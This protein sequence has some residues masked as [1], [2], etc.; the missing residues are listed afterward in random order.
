MHRVGY[1]PDPW[2]WTPWEYAGTYGRF[3]GRWDDPHGTWRTLY[4]GFSALACYLEVLAAFRADPLLADEV[5]S[6]DD[7]GD[8]AR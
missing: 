3:H 8:D 5:G 1:R 2:N 6:I 7:D 4:A